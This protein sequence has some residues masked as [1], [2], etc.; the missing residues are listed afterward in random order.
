MEETRISIDELM[1]LL[2]QRKFRDIREALSGLNSVDIAQLL[3][4]APEEK[5]LLLFRILP[6]EKAAEVFSEMD[7]DEQE[8]LIKGFS[9][10]EMKEVVDEMYIDDA[11]D[12][13]EEMPAVIVNKILRHADPETRKQIN[14]ILKYPED[15]AG[16]V[17]TTEYMSLK[18]NMTVDQAFDRIRSTGDEKED[19]YTCY[20]TDNS[21]H[22]QGIVTVR[23][24]LLSPGSKTAGELMETNVIS[25]NTLDDQENVAKTL[26]KYDLTAMPVVDNE[27][28]LVGIITVD[29]AI[30]V[31]Q[32]E[33]TEDF[34]KMAAVVPQEKSYFDTSVMQH[35]KNRLPWLFILMFSSIF[36]GLILEHYE[37]AFQS[38]PILV[39]L[40]P[41]LMDTGGNCGSQASTLIIRGMALDEIRLRDYF[42]AAWK[43]LRVGI[44]V[45][46]SLALVNG[47]RIYIQYH[48]KLMTQYPDEPFLAF[49][50]A[51]TIALALF[52]CVV[53]AKLLGC[54]LPML[55][56]RVGLDPAIMA[57]PMLTTIVDVSSVF[58]YFRIA[59]ALIMPYLSAA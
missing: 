20:V 29:D 37:T 12:M 26:A 38:F 32:E 52:F 33:N 41:M 3:G 9:D 46:A 47:V 16:S 45:G 34:E 43:E 48:G 8:L 30:D 50:L 57:S 59:T 36:T 23:Q 39:A 58:I 22:L 55:A 17:M 21:R 40:M 7:P 49:R 10:K 18:S 11:V 5:L 54:T 2:Q 4:E 42:K 25:A 51:A 27:N 35:V 31:I 44:I 13:V 56:K 1:D 24:L 6:K 53:V 15:S 28:R 14:D 19:I